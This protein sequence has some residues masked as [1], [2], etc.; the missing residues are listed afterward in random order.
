MKDALGVDM[1]F[2][3]A[4]TSNGLEVF[5]DLE[6]RNQQHSDDSDLQVV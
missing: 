3:Q 5:R 4:E 6:M 2:P 1:Y